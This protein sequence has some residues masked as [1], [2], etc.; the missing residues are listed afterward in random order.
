MQN[1]AYR[2]EMDGGSLVLAAIAGLVLAGLTVV[3][4]GLNA[5]RGNPLENLRLE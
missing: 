4:Q 3:L 5:A 1:F 2:I